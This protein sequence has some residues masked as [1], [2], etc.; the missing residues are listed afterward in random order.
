MLKEFIMKHPIISFLLADA[1][2]VNICRTICIVT[3]H[4]GDVSETKTE[5]SEAE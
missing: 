3:G 1:I 4:G 5:E 2:V